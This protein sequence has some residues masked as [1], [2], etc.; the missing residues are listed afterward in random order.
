MVRQPKYSK[1]EHA[2]RGRE[3]Y[4][5]RLRPV[6]DPGR[7]G[8]VVAID[9]DSDDYEVAADTLT[10]ANQLLARRPDAQ[11]WCERIGYPG[12]HRFGPVA[13]KRSP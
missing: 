4:Q 3:I 6:L 12:V 11:V 5:Q 10:A 7:R 13:V 8:E 1:E 9:V 2:R